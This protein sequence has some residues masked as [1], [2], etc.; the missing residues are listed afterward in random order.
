[1]SRR[2]A[3]SCGVILTS[4]VVAGTR[5]VPPRFRLQFPLFVLI[6]TAPS[7][8][9]RMWKRL[10]FGKEWDALSRKRSRMNLSHWTRRSMS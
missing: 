10:S 6:E 4:R 5:T 3:R 1:M 2:T 7:T 8:T 9:A